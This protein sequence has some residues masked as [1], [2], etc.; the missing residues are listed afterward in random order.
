MAEYKDDIRRKENYFSEKKFIL[1][2]LN[3]TRLFN[4]KK[5]EFT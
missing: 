2:R 4:L 1:F 3:T 5:E